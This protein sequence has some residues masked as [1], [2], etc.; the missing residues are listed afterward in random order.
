MSLA[1]RASLALSYPLALTWVPQLHFINPG[2][3][4]PVLRVDVTGDDLIASMVA[5]SDASKYLEMLA[6]GED[7]ELCLHSACPLQHG[8]MSFRY[9]CMHRRTACKD[10]GT[11]EARVADG[12]ATARQGY[13]CKRVMRVYYMP[14]AQHMLIISEGNHELERSSDDCKKNRALPPAVQQPQL[15][16]G[17]ILHGGDG[18]DV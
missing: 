8:V 13:D 7:E 12:I 4:H 18:G 16:V 5:R 10:D 11:H 1:E 15:M 2:V 9:A 6:Y 14:G 3:P 17:G